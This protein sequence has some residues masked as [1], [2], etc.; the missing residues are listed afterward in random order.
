MSKEHNLAVEEEKSLKEEMKKMEYEPLLPVEKKL[1]GISIGLG[2]VLLFV[3]VWVS[4][5]FFPGVH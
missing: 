1:I 5:T 3:F 2:V 4:R